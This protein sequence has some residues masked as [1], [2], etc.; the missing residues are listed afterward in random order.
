[1]CWEWLWVRGCGEVG[2]GVRT[3]YQYGEVGWGGENDK[4]MGEGLQPGKRVCLEFCRPQRLPVARPGREVGMG[5]EEGGAGRSATCTYVHVRTAEG[6]GGWRR[7]VRE[8]LQPVRAYMYGLLYGTSSTE[9]GIR[10]P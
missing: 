2:W 8:D 6:Q 7:G 10:S 4:P 5:G 1:M 9:L 3:L